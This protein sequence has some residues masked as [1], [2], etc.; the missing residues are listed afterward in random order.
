MTKKNNIHIMEFISYFFSSTH[1]TT[2]FSFHFSFFPLPSSVQNIPSSLSFLFL[3]CLLALW[4]RT[5]LCFFFFFFFFF[6][7][8][9]STSVQNTAL[10]LLLFFFFSSQHFKSE[11][12]ETIVT[13]ARTHPLFFFF[14]TPEKKMMMMMMMMMMKMKMK[15]IET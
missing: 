3:F 7:F 11:H 13:N 14:H 1:V 15:M 12:I 5:Q 2:L 4:S 8:P 10:L 9:L 6:F